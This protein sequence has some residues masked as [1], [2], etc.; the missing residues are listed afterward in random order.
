MFRDIPSWVFSYGVVLENMDDR[1]FAMACLEKAFCDRL[2]KEKP[3]QSV[4]ALQQCL[5]ENLRIDS[6]DFINLDRNL[7]MEIAPLYTKRN[8]QLLQKVVGK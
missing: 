6:G 4:R 3:L 7:L 5:F 2:Y 8:L 1:P